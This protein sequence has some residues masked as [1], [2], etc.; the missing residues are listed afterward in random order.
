MT[1]CQST[2]AAGRSSGTLDADLTM[3]VKRWPVLLADTKAA[4]L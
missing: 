4:I 1:C 2:R 3:I